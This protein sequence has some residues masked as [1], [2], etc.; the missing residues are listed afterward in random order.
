VRFRLLLAFFGISAFAL[1]A[2]TAAMY[3]FSDVG[4]FLGRITEEH[5]P[6]ALASLELSR[7]AGRIVTAAP[8]LLAVASES[9][10]AA[11]SRSIDAEAARLSTLLQELRGGTV[12][13]DAF[14]A[15]EPL[16]EGLR[17]NLA[18]LNELVSTRL[19]VRDRKEEVLQQL[20]ATN[21]AAQRLVAPGVVVMN[22][23]VSEWRHINADLATE[24]ATRRVAMTELGQD[25]VTFLPYQKALTDITAINDTLAKAAAAD[26]L[27]D[28]P[29]LAFPLHRSLDALKALASELD[30]S[31]RSKLVARIDEFA[32]FVDGP[33]SILAARSEE[34]AITTKAKALLQENAALSNKLTAAVDRL[35][36]DAKSDIA[37]ANAQVI[38]VQRL[39]SAVL[40][41]VVALSLATSIL[42]VWLYVD[43][44][45]IARLTALSQSMLAV[46]SGN[47]R[48]PL[49]PAGK[50]EIGR[51]AKA[52]SVFRDTAVEVEE[53]RLR[54]R[55]AVLDTI[56]YGVLILD[57]ALRVRIYNRALV[58]MSGIDE[59]ILS[60][61]PTF[62]AV[63]EAARE[64]G[65]GVRE[66]PDEA[67][68]AYVEGRIAEARAGSVPPREM[69]L[70]DGRILEYQVVQLP[71]G[72]RMVTYFDLTRLKRAEEALFAA[73]EQ[74]ERA[75]RAKS[76]FLASMSHEL[77]TP[78]NAIIGFTRLVM[79]HG[80]E[81]LP[82]R[83]R[84]NLE[85]I[86]SSANHLLGLINDV[87]DLSKI[88]A[89]RMEVRPVEFALE[90]LV[91]ECLRTIEPMVRSDR[92]QLGEDVA[93]DVPILFTDRDKLRQILIN[94][95]S[96]AAK[97]TQVGAIT[98][99]AQLCDGMMAIA[100]ADT[101][102]GIPKDAQEQIFEDFKQVA[103]SSVRQRDGTGLGLSISRRLARLM[104]GDITVEST[105][106][107]G[108]TFTA[109]V[110]AHFGRASRGR[111]TAEAL[112]HAGRASAVAAAPKALNGSGRKLVLAIDDDP[113]VIDLLRQSLGDEGYRVEGAAS[114]EE[115]LEKARNFKPSAITLDIIMLETDGW[116]IL[117]RL[118]SDVATR[119]IPV[120]LLTVV[121][122]KILGYELGAADYLLKPADRGDLL[123]ALARAVPRC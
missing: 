51:M 83:Q 80:A 27:A 111:S 74:A 123:A 106:G 4:R 120:I 82:E 68:P 9:Q 29:L 58:R 88:E 57:P 72:G 87:L 116:Q 26:A 97:F 17:G 92:V 98:I 37:S 46:A 20:S 93:A 25:I 32:S 59:A 89:G 48:A 115:G 109:T 64:R 19:A 84:T 101:G 63:I 81:M 76:E 99:R 100:V 42:I 105:L 5:V 52:L 33:D 65:V 30:P 95:L 85:K 28:L 70:E 43:R 14:S 2:A 7:Q 86:L 117:H 90:P 78:M 39:S 108:A 60:G 50:D 67:W 44:N 21:I 47:L 66:V 23:K 61:N 16:V 107:A 36:G 3:A 91:D 69:A 118:K 41:G 94:L 119:D 45:L 38:S 18:S 102:I 77:R 8:A 12:E 24:E 62:A 1:I 114:G 13:P 56:D 110:P 49:P 34:L 112:H 22:Y 75:N 15:I 104:G 31:L 35:V 54:E 103:D 55:Q 79:R 6:S 71:D 122:Y 121:D 11:V 53:N 40:I 73:K 96:N 113:D 10:H